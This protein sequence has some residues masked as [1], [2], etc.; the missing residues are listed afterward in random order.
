VLAR[1]APLLIAAGVACSTPGTAQAQR[2][3]QTDPAAA[4][5]RAHFET[6]AALFNA[7]N[8]DGALVEF[9]E[10]YRLRPVPVVLFNIAQ[11]LKLLYR[12]EEAIA[13]YEQYLTEERAIDAARR[14]AVQQTIDELRAATAPITVTTDT[15]GAEIRVD[16][17]LIGTTPLP[18]PLVLAAG[19]R[20]IEATLDGREATQEIDVVGGRAAEV[21][22]TIP[23]PPLDTTAPP[24]A[25]SPPLFT[26]WWFWT[27][28]GGAVL[29]GV[30]LAI[31]LSPSDAE[32]V[33]GTLG[34]VRALTW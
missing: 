16:G 17:R 33:P 25:D 30:V 4:E 6:G 34:T 14:R 20:R 19:S 2:R 32:P 3:A 5:A 13:A 11:T 12:Y 22:L 31:A 29:G 28:I 15:P 10:S 8:Y 9:Q 21:T 1:W 27:A 26:R 18:G 7:Q 23:P 24:R